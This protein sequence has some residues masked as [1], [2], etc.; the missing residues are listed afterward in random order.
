MDLKHI[1]SELSSLIEADKKN[2]TH[3]YILLKEVEDKELWKDN[4]KS[5]T[6]WVKNFCIKTKTHESII[7]NRKKAGKVYDSYKEVQA[8]KG[9]EVKPIEEVSVSADSL[10]LLDKINKYDKEVASDLTE[11]VLNKG[12]T[13]KDLR[14][15]YKSLRPEK[16]SNNP[17]IK[18]ISELE[19]EEQP[20]EPDNKNNSITAAEI[21]STLYKS[22]WL[23]DKKV[24][25]KYFKTSFEQDK[26]RAFTEFPTFTGTSKKSRRMD[27]LICENITTENTWDLNLHC[28]E[29]KVSKGDLLNDSKYTEYT[30][31]V[32]YMWLAIPH[33]LI[34]VAQEN[35]FNECGIIAID[36]NKKAKIIVSAQELKPLRR[37][38]TLTNIALKLI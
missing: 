36:K 18:H 8:S 33:D 25:R 29:I 32:N 4:Y 37:E 22:D 7:W 11:K 6:Q 35:K 27:L 26:Y 1:E 19:P 34:E 38:D 23:T 24:T 16:P 9:I 2:W 10:V 3:F 21:V 20:K 17:Q 12:I 30:E 14:E 13:K 31:F 28:I 15:V 5:F